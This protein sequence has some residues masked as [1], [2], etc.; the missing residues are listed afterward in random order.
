MIASFGDNS[1]IISTLTNLHNLAETLDF[2]W[3]WQYLYAIQLRE[4]IDYNLL[5]LLW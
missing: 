4:S 5:L 1:A 3:N 2:L